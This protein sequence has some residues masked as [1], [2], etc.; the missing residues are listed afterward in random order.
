MKN[1]RVKVKMFIL[2]VVTVVVLAASMLLSIWTMKSIDKRSILELEQAIRTDYD[3][4]LK[5]HVDTVLTM[6]ERVY[7]KHLDGEF[8][9]EEAKRLAADLVRDMRYGNGEY[10]WIDTYEGDNIVL[11]GSAKEGTNRLNDVD[12]QGF[13]LV[14]EFIR[15]GKQEDGGYLDYY[16]PKVGGEE[17]FPKRGYSKAFEPFQWIIGTGNYTDYIDEEIADFS[18]VLRSEE[19]RSITALVLVNTILLVLMGIFILLISMEITKALKVSLS[20]VSTVAKGDFSISLPKSFLK[21]K[22]DFGILTNGLENMKQQIRE[23][24]LE[25]QR[26]SSNVS[27]AMEQVKENMLSLN[28]DTKSVSLVTEQLAVSMERTATSS[29]D[30]HTM[31]S[32]IEEAARNIADRSQDGEHQAVAIHE[33]A[34]TVEAENEQSRAYTGQLHKSIHRSLKQALKDIKIVEQIEV[35]SSAIMTITS[36]TNLLALNASI[37]AA[38]AGESGRGFAVVAGEIGNLADQS[39][40]TVAKIQ[41]VTKL[42]TEAVNNLSRDAERLLE[43]VASDVVKSYDSFNEAARKYNQ[44]ASDIEQLMTGFS[45]NSQ[46][47]LASID[48]TA[49]SLREISRIT[50]ESA[51]G[52]KDIADKIGNVREVSE[53]I[54][55]LVEE[56]AGYADK[57]QT[58]MAAFTV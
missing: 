20:Y 35:L 12:S 50:G 43:F 11:Y 30:I 14:S 21:R 29:E 53:A 17:S 38:R 28:E 6:I 7:Q 54:T 9:L 18:A 1:I 8:S 33:R 15:V 25:I 36:Q 41:E 10:F 23:M 40:D 31:A 27:A 32:E 2:L 49:D 34:E 57:L 58:C 56:C 39:K 5:A 51:E 13:P 19:T 26:E 3:K 45:A 44:D 47:L 48:S 16:F 22:D 42:V 55:K 24:I 46:Q 37:E 4:A 52:T